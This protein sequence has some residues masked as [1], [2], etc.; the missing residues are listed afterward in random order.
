MQANFLMWVMLVIIMDFTLFI[1]EPNDI[2]IIFIII[3]I[4]TII[5]VL[6]INLDSFNNISS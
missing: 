6:I 2:I 1:I 5:K 3:N 4:F